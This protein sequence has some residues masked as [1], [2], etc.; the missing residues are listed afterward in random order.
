ME[1]QYTYTAVIQEILTFL[2]TCLF[3]N[4]ST[5]HYVALCDIAMKWF[6]ENDPLRIE[7]FRNI[8]W[9]WNINIEEKKLCAFCW[10]SVVNWC[11][12]QLGFFCFIVCRM[13]FFSTI[14]CNT[15]SF[16]KPS[17][18][19][20]TSI[21]L[22]HHISKRSKQFWSNFGTVQFAAPHK[23]MIQI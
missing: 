12:V 7:T 23:A 15:S 14:L 21:L 13:F 5:A 8:L 9:Y 4:M 19:L 6:L 22:Q 2:T 17:V 1:T 3:C 10:F 18:Q 20:I 16:F 11:L